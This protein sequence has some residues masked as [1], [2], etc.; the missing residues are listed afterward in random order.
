MNEQNPASPPPEAIQPKSAETTNPL[1][2]EQLEAL[3]SRDKAAHFLEGALSFARKNADKL[4]QKNTPDMPLSEEDK[5]RQQQLE[6]ALGYDAAKGIEGC[7]PALRDILNPT[8]LLPDEGESD[9][10]ENYLREQ[11]SSLTKVKAQEQ[12]YSYQEW[13]QKKATM[14]PEEA[15]AADEKALYYF[16]FPDEAA[17][18]DEGE[19]SAEK[20]LAQRAR[21]AIQTERQKL[22]Q[23]K[24]GL[25]PQDPERQN[26]EKQI[27]RLLLAENADGEIGLL[28]QQQ[29]LQQIDFDGKDELLQQ[30]TESEEFRAAQ[31]KLTQAIEQSGLDGEKL[32]D[33]KALAEQPDG[34]VQ[35]L[36][37]QDFKNI[38]DIKK[39]LFGDNPNQDS[40]I[41]SIIDTHFSPAEAHKLKGNL[42][43]GLLVL[44][45]L[46]LIPIAVGTLGATAAVSLTK[47]VTTH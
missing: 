23:Q 20:P 31:Q 26:M 15:T 25:Q 43:K 3:P 44:L 1:T 38:P 39:L 7:S 10:G 35:L 14:T 2:R 13:Q 28:L 33:L 19:Q 30:L 9:E 12:E 42:D 27:T 21:T 17:E 37:N 34:I 45:I 4:Q 22:E 32:T 11:L 16:S 8:T 41:G 46:G 5:K 6:S 18:E 47:Q 36:E 24:N 29:I 40:V